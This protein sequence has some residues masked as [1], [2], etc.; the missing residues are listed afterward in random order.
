[1]FKKLFREL[2]KHYIHFIH[3]NDCTQCPYFCDSHDI[4]GCTCGK[5][6]NT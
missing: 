3:K 2:E 5:Y 1:M 6:P 4:W